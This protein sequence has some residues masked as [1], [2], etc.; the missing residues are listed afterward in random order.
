MFVD[1]HNLMGG[2]QDNPITVRVSREEVGAINSGKIIIGRN[3][4]GNKI[5]VVVMMEDEPK[6]ISSS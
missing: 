5:Q 4:R 3:A 6:A 2:G 1:D